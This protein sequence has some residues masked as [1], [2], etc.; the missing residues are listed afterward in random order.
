[1][2]VLLEDKLGRVIL[3]ACSG[4]RFHKFGAAIVECLRIVFWTLPQSWDLLLHGPRRISL[5]SSFADFSPTASCP[6]TIWKSQVI[7]AFLRRG[8][9]ISRH[10]VLWCISMQSSFLDFSSI[11]DVEVTG[12][13][14]V[15]ASRRL[16]FEAPC[17]IAQSRLTTGTGELGWLCLLFIKC[18]SW[19]IDEGLRMS[20]T[21]KALRSRISTRLFAPGRGWPVPATSLESRA[22][23]LDKLPRRLIISF[24]KLSFFIESCSITIFLSLSSCLVKLNRSLSCF[25]FLSIAFRMSFV[26]RR[27]LGGWSL[28]V[29]PELSKVRGKRWGKIGVCQ[30]QQKCNFQ[31]LG[32]RSCNKS[33]QKSFS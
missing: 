18:G 7:V 23:K 21:E 27:N 16:H 3:R 10:L 25:A 29:R 33:K 9:I 4:F 17:L 5:Q 2:H 12:Y 6:F 20:P 15:L 11:Y 28:I 8:D 32:G 1:M 19:Q 22:F 26:G 14:S 13:R 31:A 30:F 24:L